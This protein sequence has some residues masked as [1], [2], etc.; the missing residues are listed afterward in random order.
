[1]VESPATAPTLR[2]AALAFIFVTVTLDIVAFGI[3][4]PVLPMLIKQMAGGESTAAAHWVG[5]ISTIFAI[6]QLVCTPIQGAL[7]DR[8]GR[9]KVILLSN[10]GLGL[11][12]FLMAVVNSLPM[13][14]VA[15]I[16]SG[17]TSASFSTANAYIA[18]ITPPEKRAATYGKLGASFGIGFVLGPAMGG[19]LGEIDLRLPFWVAGGLAL[20]NFAY[21]YFILPESLPPERRT[22]HLDIR[23]ANPLGSLMLLRRYP[24]VFSLATVM[25]LSQ[26]AHY[27][28]NTTFVL[29]VDY[30]Y[31]WGPQAVGFTLGL[32][33]I[34][35]G[36]VQAILVGKIVQRFGERRALL[37]GL[38][39]GVVGFAW[40]G[41]AATGWIALFAIPFLALWGFVN[42]ATQALVTRQVDPHEQ[43]RLQGALA[44]LVS[45]AGVIGPELYTQTFAWGIGK[46]NSW[47]LPGAAFLLAALLL[48]I[49]A[50]IAHRATRTG[51]V[52]SAASHQA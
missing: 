19:F 36:I 37:A 39:F 25:F 49:G 27:V 32:V 51:T 43:G 4:I 30:R 1:M 41:L 7:S 33:G 17:M 21:G 23:N 5:I 29:Y 44:S 16:I 34:C 6:V 10:L 24:Q 15:R 22:R 31:G 2:R 48:G 13:L 52:A 14:V 42:P 47:H 26:L 45:L 40:Q 8:Y 11:D 20:A 35:N 50:V 28:L 12:F 38:L 9:R 46:D 3:I 18:D